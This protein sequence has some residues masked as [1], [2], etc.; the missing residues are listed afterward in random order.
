VALDG[1]GERGVTDVQLCDVH[2]LPMPEVRDEIRVYFLVFLLL[3]RSFLGCRS[4]GSTSGHVMASF[5]L[6]FI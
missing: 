2:I 5:A 3:L 1:G 4:T 6:G